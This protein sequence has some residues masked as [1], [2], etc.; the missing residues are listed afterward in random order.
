MASLSSFRIFFIALLVLSLAGV[1]AKSQDS[2]RPSVVPLHKIPSEQ[3]VEKVWG[4]PSKPGEPFVIRIHNDAGY[5]V[6]PHVHPMDENIVVVQGVWWFGMGSRFNRSA[7]EP[8]ELGA[9]GFGPKNMAHFAWSKTETIIQVHG[10]GPFSTRLV[11]PVYELTDKGL[12]LL[13]ALLQP[14]SPTQSSPRDCFA[15]KIGTR[16]RGDAGEGTVIGARC[17][18]ANQLTQYWVRKLDGDRFWATL[19]G[20]KAM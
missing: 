14:G 13:T 17:S 9:F 11:D 10:T 7:M 16:V 1:K 2:L 3:W 8:L 18:P 19:E 4:D 6:L 5:V 12:F 20:L 15:L